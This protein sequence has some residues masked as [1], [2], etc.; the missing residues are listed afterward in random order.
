L[1][2]HEQDEKCQFFA[3]ELDCLIKK[4]NILVDIN[5]A[6][7]TRQNN[8]EIEQQIEEEITEND[9]HRQRSID[10]NGAQVEQR[11]QTVLFRTNQRF[12]NTFD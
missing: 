12:R 9:E 6:D 7:S 11:A 8:D 2:R 10:V 3:P 4:S 1:T 5:D